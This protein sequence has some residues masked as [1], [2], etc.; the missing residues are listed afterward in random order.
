MKDV[1]LKPATE[2]CSY[3]EGKKLCFR[4]EK[5][6]P[7]P[8]ETAHTGAVKALS[9]GRDSFSSFQGISED[10]KRHY[11]NYPGNEM[12]SGPFFREP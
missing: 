10:G 2:Y 11:S 12:I 1:D 9:S 4:R 3:S 5:V 6:E 8:M 7:N